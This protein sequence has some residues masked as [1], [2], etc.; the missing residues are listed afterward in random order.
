MENGKLWAEIDA[1]P[2]SSGVY[3][4]YNPKTGDSYVGSSLNIR[5]RCFQHLTNIAN[6]S[7]TRALVKAFK[8]PEATFRVEA[9]KLCSR[10]DL[11]SE[12]R[13]FIADLKP[14]LN[15]RGSQ[16][17]KETNDANLITINEAAKLKGVSRQAIHA[18][19][20]AGRIECVEVVTKSKRITPKALAAFHPNPNRIKAAKSSA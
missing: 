20:E 15:S 11:D 6:G 14:S 12:E 13:K 2:S 19:I 16:R 9:L 3:R 4:I 7:S 10:A 1:L 17:V 8:S 5:T 18:A